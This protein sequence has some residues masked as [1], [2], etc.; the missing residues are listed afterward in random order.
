MSKIFFVL[1]KSCS[2]KDT[3]FQSLKENKQLNLKN[4]FLI[5]YFL[6]F[7]LLIKQGLFG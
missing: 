1:G 6:K 7:F 2:G 5:F 3:I 4:K